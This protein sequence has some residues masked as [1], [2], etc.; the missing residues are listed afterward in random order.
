MVRT[1]IASSIVIGLHLVSANAGA[2]S[3]REKHEDCIEDCRIEF[4]MEVGRQ[5]LFKCLKRCETQRSDCRDLD[6]I[7]RDTR[8]RQREQLRREAYDVPP[9]DP[10]RAYFPP[11]RDEPAPDWEREPV[12]EPERPSS[13]SSESLPEPEYGEERPLVRIEG[14]HSVVVGLAN[15]DELE[16]VL[17]SGKQ[18]GNGRMAVSAWA[19]PGAITEAKSRGCRVKVLMSAAKVRA[20]WQKRAREREAAHDD[21]DRGGE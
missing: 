3:C 5:N 4:G 12:G 19:S 1:V 17:G 20:S 14:P 21:F 11:E 10:G 15:V 7:Q 8:R 9:I 6:R 18:L 2:S 13:S 16:L